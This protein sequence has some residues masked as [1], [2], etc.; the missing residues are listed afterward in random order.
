MDSAPL[1]NGIES[2][3]HDTHTVKTDREQVWVVKMPTQ[4]DDICAIECDHGP[5][6]VI[7]KPPKLRN[8]FCRSGSG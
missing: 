1:M 4:M 7:D 6:V 2:L 3:G 5:V 8:N